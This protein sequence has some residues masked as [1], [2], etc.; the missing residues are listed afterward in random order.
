MASEIRAATLHAL[1]LGTQFDIP[2]EAL[3]ECLNA[4]PKLLGNPR[5]IAAAESLIHRALA[6]G[7]RIPAPTRAEV[8]PVLGNVAEAVVEVILEE[9]GWQPVSD[10]TAGFSSAH[11]I[12][13][14]MLDPAMERVVAIEVKSTI[15]PSRW[16]RLAAGR[17]EQLTPKWFDT[18]RNQGMV[19][20]G[21]SATDVFTMVV[22]VHLR[23]RRWRAC[24]ASDL[25]Q[26][27]PLVD[28][29]QLASLEWVSA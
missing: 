4:E 6:D 3:A 26:P 28:L 27:H 24:L 25:R 10:D 2:T 16:P 21:L 11:G 1:R 15:Q 29:D 20:W 23:R 18:P 22:Q 17:R 9:Q 5:R 7:T 14:L 8:L 13:L 19:E 12:D